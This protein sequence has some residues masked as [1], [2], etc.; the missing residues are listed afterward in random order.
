[1]E[2][3]HSTGESAEPVGSYLELTF[4]IVILFLFIF[5]FSFCFTG[6]ER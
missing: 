1:L 2:P 6:K 3:F 4:S 5:K